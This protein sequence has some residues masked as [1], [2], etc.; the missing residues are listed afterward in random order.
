MFE[1]GSVINAQISA[2]REIQLPR[3]CNRCMY[4]KQFHPNTH[5]FVKNDSLQDKLTLCSKQQAKSAENFR[6][7]KLPHHHYK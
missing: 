4:H 3:L 1:S 6:G 2:Y 5:F 7:S